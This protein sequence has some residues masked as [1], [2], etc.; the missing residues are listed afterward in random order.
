MRRAMP[1]GNVA[2]YTAIRAIRERAVI[3]EIIHQAL[4][5][6]NAIDLQDVRIFLLDLNRLKKVLQGESLGVEKAIFRLGDVFAYKM[7]REMAVNALGMSMM[8]GMLP[9]VV[10]IA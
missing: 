3:D 5:A 8:A 9:A 6:L 10:L 4:M 1:H 2:T 7:V